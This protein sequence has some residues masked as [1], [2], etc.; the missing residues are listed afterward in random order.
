MNFS[1]IIIVG[2]CTDL[3]FKS[4][5]IS[6]PRHQSNKSSRAVSEPHLASFISYDGKYFICIRLLLSH[7]P[8]MFSSIDFLAAHDC[9]LSFV[10]QNRDLRIEFPALSNASSNNQTTRGSWSSRNAIRL[11]NKVTKMFKSNISHVLKFCSIATGGQTCSRILAFL[12]LFLDWP[13]YGT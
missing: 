4:S 6:C 12:C 9:A 3:I 13:L 2:N 5:Q 11:S 8:F 1:L 7:L 10:N